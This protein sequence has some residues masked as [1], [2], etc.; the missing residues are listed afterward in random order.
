DTLLS[1]GG[2]ATRDKAGRLVVKA[3]EGL[4]GADYDAVLERFEKAVAVKH[5]PARILTTN[6][7][8]AVRL[9]TQHNLGSLVSFVDQ[10]GIRHRGVLVK[11]GFERKLGS[12]SLR[13]DGIEA[14]FRALADMHAEVT[15][16]PTGSKR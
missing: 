7:F 9:A 1:M 8:R 10:D 3:G 12:L 14:T 11:K 2:V 15:S 13:V 4:E 6:L 16:S 5:T